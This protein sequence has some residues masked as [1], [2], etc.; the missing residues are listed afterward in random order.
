MLSISPVT[1]SS[2]AGNY[3]DSDNY[4]AKDDPEAKKLSGWWGKTAE[5]LGLSGEIDR[6]QF[7]S[8]L[9][10]KMPNGEQLGIVKDGQNHHRNG[11]DLT[12]SAPKSVSLM[13]EIG[14]DKRLLTAH[15]NAVNATLAQIESD[16]AS[17][18]ITRKGE[19]TIE[20]SGNLAVAKFLHDTSR[21]LDPQL[22]TH[23]VVLN[24]T[25]RED[26]KIRS[27]ASQ[28][29]AKT[30][31]D[32]K[33]GFMERL[34]ENKLYYG[35][36]Y[37]SHLAY[38]VNQLGYE[39]NKTHRDGR[40]EL[41][42][43][44]KTILEHFSKRR[45]DIEHAM[46]THGLEGAKDAAYA[47]ILTRANKQVVSHDELRAFWQQEAKAV[48]FKPEAILEQANV[49][50]QSPDKTQYHA[51]SSEKSFSFQLVASFDF[52]SK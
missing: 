35:S 9:N 11:Y 51:P 8:L 47:T 17:A 25:M 33:A 45:A 21:A 48:G 13:L 43:I 42:G 16:L 24:A 37:R 36:L 20:H 14:G 29:H 7:V 44:N 50:A 23:A 5:T 3:F 40:F 2:K 30:G 18:R 6:E 28:S 15:D 31:V 10:G 26:G 4:Y 38:E 12:F 1:N 49:R 32:G 39:V 27:L 34:F 52:L 46:Q 19:T 41:A 22:H